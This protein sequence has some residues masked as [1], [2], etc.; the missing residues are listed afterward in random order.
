[1]NAQTPFTTSGNLL[2]SRA[3]LAG[4]TIR[5]WSARKLDKKVTREVNESHNAVSDAG[6]YNKSLLAKG[7]LEKIQ[8]IASA[9]RQAH[10]R[11]TLP[12][13]D[14]GGRILPTAA[15]VE[16]ANNVREARE[17]FESAVAEFV[18]NYPAYVE[19]SRRRLNGMFD[20]NDYPD[21]ERI[22]RAFDFGTRILPMP[23]AK[24]FRAEIGEAQAADLRAQIEA[25]TTEAL[26][27]AMREVWTRVA[28]VVGKMSERLKAYK[29][30]EKKG[31]KSEGVFRDSLVSNVAD[32]VSIL[33]ALNLTNDPTLAEITRKMRD[34]L[35]VYDADTLRESDA[36]RA[37][38][39]SAAD[40]IMASVEAFI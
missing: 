39:A 6:R 13:L 2:A 20:P 23:D 38:V 5:Q 26:A 4:L 34:G 14:E 40:S 37:T 30:A 12:W 32:L 7:A 19:D 1:M 27:G 29:P 31:D 22:K 10:Y 18:A 28:D 8:T 16:Y 33:P 3:M 9:A 36:I 35:T 17:A 25:S 24:D 21:A 11:L 15:F